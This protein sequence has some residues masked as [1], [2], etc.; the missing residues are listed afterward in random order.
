[1]RPNIVSPEILEDIL[2]ALV[3]AGGYPSKEAAVGHALEVLLVANPHLR[4]QTAIEFYR[5]GKVTLSR[6]AEVAQLELEAFK[7]QLAERDLSI[8]V[9]EAPDDVRA[10]VELIQ[11][12]KSSVCQKQ[13]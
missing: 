7:E 4:T 5:R 12:L 11:R 6:A 9:D 8:E 10:G 13:D 3:R 2:Q 1:M